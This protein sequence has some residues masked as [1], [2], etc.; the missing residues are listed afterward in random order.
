MT[1]YKSGSLRSLNYPSDAKESYNYEEYYPNQNL[2]LKYTRVSAYYKGVMTSYYENGKVRKVGMANNDLI[3]GYVLSFTE[4]GKLDSVKFYEKNIYKPEIDSTRIKSQFVVLKLIAEES[5]RN[6]DRKNELVANLENLRKTEEEKKLKDQE[7]KHQEDEIKRKQLELELLTKD[8][9]V[10]DLTIKA[11]EAELLK[12]MLLANE[13]KKEIE[14]LNQQK[15]IDELSIKNKE[16]EIARQNIEAE[17]K[18]KQIHGLEKEKELGEENLKQQ[19][20]I[21]KLILAG[22][23]L[24]GVFLIFVFVSLARSRKANKVIAQQKEEVERQKN[25]AEQ[26]RSVAEEQKH[27]IE[28][29]QKEIVDSISYAKHLQ[30]AILPPKE[31]ISKH[32]PSNF[33]LYKPKDIVAGDFYWAEQV[34]NNFFIAAADCTGHGVPGAMVSVVCSNALNRAVKEFRLNETGK[35]LDKTRELVID[36]F[37]KS[38]EEVK[39]GMDISMLRISKEKDQTRVQWSGANN[40]LWYIQNNELTEVKADK[41]PIGKYHE[42]KDFTTHEFTFTAPVTFYLYSDGYADQFSADDKKLMRKKFKDIVV[43]IQHLTMPEQMKY[44]DNYHETW[45]GSMEQT[46]DVLVIGVMV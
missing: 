37:E 4:T 7:L 31:F 1:F 44:L 29:K 17:N 40:A 9:A 19:K 22:A 13:K 8:K 10:S 3:N 15:L 16:A 5:N 27:L 28:E 33:I 21:Q 2:Q 14:N 18:Q 30:Q 12:N 39:D 46:D 6:V 24:L 11:K 25:I 43:S 41:Q 23:G 38:G 42:T 34:G 45:K 35:I 20:F 32:V 36:T 26:Q